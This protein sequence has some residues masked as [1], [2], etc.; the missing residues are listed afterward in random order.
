MRESNMR[1]EINWTKRSMRNLSKLG[2]K[3]RPLAKKIERRTSSSSHQFWLLLVTRLRRC[4]TWIILRGLECRYWSWVT[5][6]C[7]SSMSNVPRSISNVCP[8]PRLQCPSSMSNVLRSLSNVPWSMSN[9]NVQCPMSMS[10]VR[11]QCPRSQGHCLMSHDQCPMTWGQCPKSVQCPSSMSN[12]PRSMSN[13]HPMSN[14]N[15]QCLSSKSNVLR[16]LSNVPSSMSN[17]WV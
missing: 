9:V 16:S 13:V 17:V 4:L 7:P 3:K 6:Q 1:T 2:L 15:V 11:V 8:M 12:V 5:V 14:F 10:N